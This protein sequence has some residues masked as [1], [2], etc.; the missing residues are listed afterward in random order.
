MVEQFEK[1][2]KHTG[3]RVLLVHGGVGY[4]K[5]RKGLQ[6]GAVSYTHLDVYKRQGRRSIF[7][8]K[9]HFA[10]I[11]GGVRLRSTRAASTS[12]G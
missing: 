3:L 4:D 8:L 7:R 1:Y 9:R 11:R 6:E 5:Q 12:S 10:M 2:G